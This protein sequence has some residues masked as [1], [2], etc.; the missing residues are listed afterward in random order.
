MVNDPALDKPEKADIT[1][2]TSQQWKVAGWKLPLAMRNL[3]FFSKQ[4]QIERALGAIQSFICRVPMIGKEVEQ[5]LS[6]TY[7][8]RQK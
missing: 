5:V 6:G 7:A 1:G 2:V 3:Y 4:G 8:H